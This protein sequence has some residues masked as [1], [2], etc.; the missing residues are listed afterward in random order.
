M[1]GAEAYLYSGFPIKRERR[2]WIRIIGRR[3][4]D[5]RMREGGVCMT[6][7]EAELW[8]VFE[9]ERE[10]KLREKKRKFLLTV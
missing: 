8:I 9:G 3:G 1:E 10:G 5:L 4:G 7:P 2:G 6:T